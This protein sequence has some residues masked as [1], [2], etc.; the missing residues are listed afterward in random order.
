M[1]K[2][3]FILSILA[4]MLFPACEN[5]L[6]YMDKP[7]APQLL[8]NAFLE[9]G[10]EENTVSLRMIEADKQQ[11][12]YV[13]NGS[14]VVYVNGEKTE[15]AQVDKGYRS[16]GDPNCMLKTS[17]RPGDRIRFEATAEDGQY[18]AG[19]EVEIP[20]PI[21]DLIR[22]DTLRTQL[23][24]S[25]SMMDCMQYKITIHDRPNEK[26]YYRLIIE[27][28]T[29]RV[30]S[31]TGTR[32][33]PFPFYPEIIN[34]EDIVLTDGHLTT[35]DDDKFGILD[36]TIRN[37]NNVFT[38]GRF[39]NGSYTLKV[40][41]SIPYIRELNRKDHFYLDVT[42]RLLSL[43]QSYYRYLRAM[44][45]LDSEDYNETFMEPVIVPQNVSGGL[46]FVGASSE[47]RVT[48]R[49]VDR[50]PLW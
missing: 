18:Q 15:T 31:E 49:M 43:S 26:N 14:I 36:W 19:C 10:K 39:E 24:G 16:F 9:A 17:F 29:Y 1:K 2:N 12:D 28:N 37:T 21:E 8:M 34:Q 45:C 35:A 47:Q 30:S 33:G 25:S 48:L 27:E 11:A 40:Y 20:L 22:V 42:V 4:S 50:P 44:N 32:Y 41:T 38:D 7:Q 5:E 13:S 23:R 3:L 46:G 6:P